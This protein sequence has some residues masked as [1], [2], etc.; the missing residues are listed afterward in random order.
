MARIVIFGAAG[1]TGRNIVEQAVSRGH[2]VTAFVHKRT[3]SFSEVVRI[4]NGD[5][6]NPADIEKAVA[7]QDAVLSALGRGSSPRPVTFP[8]TKNI[9]DAMDKA[10]VHRLIVES[11]FGA[12]ESA[13]EISIPDR[14][15]VR[16][17]VLRSS[18]KDKD[19]MEACVEKSDLRWTIVRPPRLTDGPRRGSYR[20]GERIPLNIAS[21]ISRADVAD[22]MLSQ[23]EGGEYIGKKPSL[24]Y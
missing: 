5:V 15:F 2:A 1:R 13:K 21:G 9:V 20:A 19:L 24:A 7:S 10:G 16:G 6:L 8:G 14:L 18:F 4:I 3:F 17:L 22:F 11:A 23:V 12:G